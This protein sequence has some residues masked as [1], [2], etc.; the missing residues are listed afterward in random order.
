MQ[1]STVHPGV[2]LL[3]NSDLFNSRT[4]SD[5]VTCCHCVQGHVNCCTS[6]LWCDWN[7]ILL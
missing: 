1:H 2:C 3:V 6:Q 5:T 4:A 7:T